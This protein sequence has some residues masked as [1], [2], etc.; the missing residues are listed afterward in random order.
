[1]P[2]TDFKL[3]VAAIWPGTHWDSGRVAFS[4]EVKGFAKPW[5]F[6]LPYSDAET[7]EAG[8][9]QAARML[10]ALGERLAEEATELAGEA[11]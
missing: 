6:E 9:K 8:V 2:E 4:F 3:R 10:A 5:E 1:M 7:I 11:D